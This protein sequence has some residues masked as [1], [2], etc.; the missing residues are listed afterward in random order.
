MIRKYAVRQE[1]EG[2]KSEDE[3]D[4][5]VEAM[6]AQEETSKLTC[7]GIFSDGKCTKSCCKLT[8]YLRCSVGVK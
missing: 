5:H 8:R 4:D 7:K 2:D 1:T 6:I 3:E